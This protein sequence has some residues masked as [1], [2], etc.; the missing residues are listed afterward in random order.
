MDMDRQISKLSAQVT[1]EKEEAEAYKHLQ[2]TS[3]MSRSRTAD[4]LHVG[5]SPR[6]EVNPF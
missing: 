5:Y 3:E 4:Q 1:Q 2:R 6:T